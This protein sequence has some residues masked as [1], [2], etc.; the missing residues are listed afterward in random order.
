MPAAGGSVLDLIG[1]LYDTLVDPERWNDFLIQLCAQLN[2]DTAAIAL[3]DLDNQSPVI[4]LAIG[5]SDRLLGE[6]NREY[7]TKNPRAPE[8]RRE[9]LT[10]GFWFGVNSMRTMPP[11]F[12]DHPYIHWLQRND[13]YHSIVVA[14]RSSSLV[15]SLNVTRRESAVPFQATGRKLM[16]QLVPHLQ[17][18]VQIH[19]RNDT[20]RTLSEAGKFAL[21]RIDTAVIGVNEQQEVILTNRSAD[22][23][24]TTGRIIGIRGR[25]L[26][27]S[28]F[29]QAAAF[30]QLLQ[31][32]AQPR[33]GDIASSGGVM[34]IRDERMTPV[35]IIVTPFRSTRVLG[36]ERLCALVFIVDQA[37]KP[38]SRA[39]V[40]RDVF[41]L[42]PA[43]CRLSE[44]LHQGL[45]LNTV[46]NRLG[47]T[48]E[49]S[50]FMLKRIFGKTGSH[51]QS[52]LLQ[53]LSRLPSDSERRAECVIGQVLLPFRAQC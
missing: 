23:I 5:M 35:S 42:S 40:L 33:I 29:S 48:A 37:A 21:D 19:S 14:V 17:R 22:A 34:T 31:S 47:V 18:A 10:S 1:L 32:A 8:I 39:G 16:T 27:S 45:D 25:K 2:C 20:V 15:T 7:G 9:V 44:M 28:N 13:L 24:L 52:H 12:Q 46:A 50:R 38:L 43:E 30:E 11:A 4:Q 41:G 3:H 53:L 51:R 6:W 26:V 49:T 36:D